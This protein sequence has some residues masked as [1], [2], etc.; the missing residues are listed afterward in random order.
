[1]SSIGER[2][3]NFKL[4]RKIVY[5]VVGLVSYP[6]LAIINKLTI[7]G[8][9][10]LKNL[11]RENVL[12][13]SNHQTYFAD[14]IAFLHIFCAVKWG[15]T[16]KLGVPY[17]LLNPFTRVNYVAAEE[18]MRG[19]WI[20]RLFALAGALTV[21]RTWRPEGTEVRKGLDPS[22]TRKITRALEKN[23]V[24]TFPQGTTKP[25]APGRKGTALIIKQNRPIVIPVVINGFWR[26]FNKKGLRFKKK[27]TRLSVRFKEPINIDYELPAEEILM[28]VMDAIEQSE[29]YMMMGR[30]HW[31]MKV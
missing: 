13:V 20:S 21:K 17:Y 4:V 24:I 7:S 10:H 14:V 26:A 29:N 18:T 9:E 30:H 22:D 16:N 15:K 6:G 11:P 12:F 1:M 27:G 3:R 5:V 25:F 19:S 2:L 8:T 31:E 23:W 28:Q